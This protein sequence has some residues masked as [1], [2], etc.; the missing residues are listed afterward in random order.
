GRCQ[1]CGPI[2]DDQLDRGLAGGIAAN[3]NPQDCAVAN[4]DDTGRGL[5]V[6]ACPSVRER[7]KL[8]PGTA[9][10]LDKAAH[11]P[12]VSTSWRQDSELAI[13][14]K[15]EVTVV[16]E[17]N[18]SLAGAR[19]L[20]LVPGNERFAVYDVAKRRRPYSQQLDLCVNSRDNSANRRFGCLRKKDDS[21]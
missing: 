5:D 18:D 21:K 17:G 1:R 13:R 20:H 2:E 16:T 14:R 10:G 15:H 12:I 3:A 9:K 19:G 7:R 6:V 4:C 8:C 11:E